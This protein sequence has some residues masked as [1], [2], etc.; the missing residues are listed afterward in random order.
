MV[1]GQPSVDGGV[2][3]AVQ[4]H[5]E[6]VDVLHLPVLALRD[7]RAQL[8]VL[9]LDHLDG[10]LQRADLHLFR[11]RVEKEE[12][13]RWRRVRSQSDDGDDGDNVIWSRCGSA[14]C[15]VCLTCV[16]KT[17]S[18]LSFFISRLVA[19]RLAVSYYI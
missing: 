19:Q 8:Q 9:V 5:G 1:A 12:Q 7:E 17:E 16:C 10:V 13:R 15:V 18:K 6:R 2:D 4:A 11:E 14:D 3:D